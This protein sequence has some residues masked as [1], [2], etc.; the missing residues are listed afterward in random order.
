MQT[1]VQA[2]ATRPTLDSAASDARGHGCALHAHPGAMMLEEGARECTDPGHGQPDHR[3]VTPA[4]LRPIVHRYALIDELL[5]ARRS[6]FGG[7]EADK[8]FVGYR[9]HAYH[10]LNFARQWIEPS[11]RSDDKLAIAAVFHDI[12]AWPDENL[13]YLGP[14]ADQAEAYLAEVGLSEWSPEMRLMIE[15]H[16][17]I[18]AYTGEH[19]EWVEPVR[20]ADWCDVSFS[21]MRFGLPRSFVKE[22]GA[23]FPLSPFYPAHVYKVSFKWLLRHPLNPVPILRW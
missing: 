18:R 16:H 17:K 10:I 6:V 11:P 20:R 15:M 23:E 21:T 13:D 8:V 5:E 22:I 7:P 19:R 2:D 14:S 4:S 1:P 9:N 3:C 12:A